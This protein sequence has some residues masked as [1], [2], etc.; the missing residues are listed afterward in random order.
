MVNISPITPDFS[1][2]LLMQGVIVKARASNCLHS[3]PI[4][5][6]FRRRLLLDIVITFLLSFQLILPPTAGRVMMSSG[7]FDDCS[8]QSAFYYH[9]Y[10]QRE[11]LTIISSELKIAQNCG[12]FD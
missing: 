9:V 11:S 6:T 2:T 5:V 8:M 3:P 10:H 4:I 7:N 12:Y 1:K